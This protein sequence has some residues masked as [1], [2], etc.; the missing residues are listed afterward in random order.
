[1]ANSNGWGDGA[2]NNAIGWG[3]GANNAISWGK[4]QIS[5]YAG[6]TDITGIPSTDADAQAF[7]TAA[8]ITDPTQ[9]AA[10]NTLVVDLKGYGIWTKSKALYPFVGGTATSHKFNLKDP[11][12]L[13]AAY[14]LVFNGGWTHSST[15]AAPNGTN[16]Y[17]NTYLNPTSAYA[18]DNNVH[19]SYYSRTNVN[20]TQVEIG[21]AVAASGSYLMLEIRTTGTTYFIMNRT[22]A[23]AT[24]L[25]TDSRAFYIGNRIGTSEKGFKNNSNVVSITNTA[26]TRPNYNFYLGAVNAANTPLFYTS[27]ESAFA[28]IG[29]GLTDTE[30]A[31]FYTAVQAFQTTLGR[32]IGTQTVSDADAQAFV[33]NADIQDQVEANA[34]NN[35]VIGM[36]ADGLWTKMKAVYPMVGGTATS[37]SF[38]L[39]NTAQ[40]Q[41]SWNGGVTHSPNGVQFGGVNGYGDTGLNAASVLGQDSTH[42]SF[43]SRTDVIANSVD[44]GIN[45]TARQ[46]Y[47]LY[48]YGSSAFKA[49]NR[50]QL[51]A[52]SLYTPTNGLLIANRS[53]STTEKYYHKGTLVDTITSLSTGTIS[54]N[55]Y[56][57]GY[58]NLAVPTSRE[59]S[60]K[61]SALISIG[62]GLTDTDA[63][64]LNSRVT[65]FQ[66]SLNR[67][68]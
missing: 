64:N 59:Y 2:A 35:F 1:M 17:A 16:A 25:D 12:D 34:I 37:N 21:S 60:S 53:S 38:N 24:A 19:L 49:M 8:A 57:G 6:L 36:K 29:D 10:I 31:N 42:F 14:R 9:Q 39:R 30:A 18:V 28:S 45:G 26:L 55:V 68:I 41:I 44:M 22:T 15:G 58:N 67:N 7:I 3:Q 52:G 54:A 48:R 4:S 65:T 51:A 27:K 11:R 13:D 50:T 66:T 56:I 40:Y 32:S 63:T 5:S 62:D 33:T 23:F 43:Y 20:T 47:L 46:L 61:Q